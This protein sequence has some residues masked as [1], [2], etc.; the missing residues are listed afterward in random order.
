MDNDPGVDKVRSLHRQ[1]AD[2]FKRDEIVTA[3]RKHGFM[4]VLCS[5][6]RPTHFCRYV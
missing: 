6:I 2:L 1:R 5:R 4:R 3:A